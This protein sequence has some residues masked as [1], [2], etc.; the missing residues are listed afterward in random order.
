MQRK[1]A[2]VYLSSCSYKGNLYSLNKNTKRG[3][4]FVPIASGKQV[5]QRVPRRRRERNEKK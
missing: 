5:R 1:R 4:L 2:S 3:F